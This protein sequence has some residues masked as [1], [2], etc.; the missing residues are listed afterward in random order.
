MKTQAQRVFDKC[1]GVPRLAIAMSK[2]PSALYRWNHTK[3]K[4]GTEGLIPTSSMQ[5]VLDAAAILGVTLTPEDLDP[6]PSEEVQ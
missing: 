2:D 1:G 3:E 5:E 6:R 4:G